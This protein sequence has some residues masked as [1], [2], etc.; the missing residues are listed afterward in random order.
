MEDNCPSREFVHGITEILR[1]EDGSELV[2]I[3]RRAQL[4]MVTTEGAACISCE[5]CPSEKLTLT[6]ASSG[7]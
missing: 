4:V 7:V 3:A 1:L 2:V 6:V 5:R